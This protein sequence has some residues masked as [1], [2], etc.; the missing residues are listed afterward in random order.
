MMSK[1][2][3]LVLGLIL[4]I[5]FACSS[6]PSARDEAIIDLTISYATAK[7]IEDRPESRETIVRVATAAKALNSGDTSLLVLQEFVD[8]EINK[9]SLSPADEALAR[10]LV[11]L[12]TAEIEAKIGEGLLSP[13]Q[14]V[15]VDRVLD[16]VIATAS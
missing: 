3:I 12:I 6:N 7:Y 4:P 13:E 9:L 5:L 16:L 8:S 2:R 1:I 11:A 15:R 14:R 10:G